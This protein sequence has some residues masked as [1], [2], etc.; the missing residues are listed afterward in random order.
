MKS[1]YEANDIQNLKLT[2]WLVNPCFLFSSTCFAYYG[3]DYETMSRSITQKSKILYNTEFS[4]QFS[5]TLG[6][7]NGDRSPTL[8]VN[9]CKSC[10]CFT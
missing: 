1:K 6:P 7:D 5:S 8:S 2:L 3:M 9:S 4:L 10:H